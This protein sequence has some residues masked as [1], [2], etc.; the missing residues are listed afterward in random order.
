ML[1]PA[2][3]RLEGERQSGRGNHTVWSPR[4]DGKV[5][6]VIE[7][8]TRSAL[9]S[10][11][12]P[13]Q[14]YSCA[15]VLSVLLEPIALAPEGPSHVGEGRKPLVWGR[16]S[17][18]SPVRGDIARRHHREP[19]RPSWGSGNITT[20]RTRGSRPWLHHAA[21]PGLR[22]DASSCPLTW[23]GAERFF[24]AARL[25]VDSFA[26]VGSLSPLA[27]WHGLGGIPS[28]P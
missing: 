8:A 21:P 12:S 18:L 5:R 10:R 23:E 14:A 6:G 9:R 20:L 26:P 17:W 27:G 22:V 7:A 4:L 15:S 24:G 1:D 19:C 28:W 2:C 13:P 25:P 11:H 3:L 16:F